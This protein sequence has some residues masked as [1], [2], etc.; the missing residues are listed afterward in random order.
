MNTG[1][2]AGWRAAFAG[3]MLLAG[4]AWA[5]GPDAKILEEWRRDA[6]A[7]EDRLHAKQ[8]QDAWNRSGD[9]VDSMVEHLGE[10]QLARELLASAASRRALAAAGLGREEEAVWLWQTAQTLHPPYRQANLQAYGPPG[11]LL[12]RHRSRL[13]W[14]IPTPEVQLLPEDGGGDLRPPRK[15]SGE[16]PRVPKAVQ[17]GGG[18]LLRIELVVDA[19]GGVSRPV[20]LG[21]ARHPAYAYRALES[22]RTWRFQPA[23]SGQGRVPVLFRVYL[24]SRPPFEGVAD[25]QLAKAE[26]LLRRGEWTA[27]AAESRRQVES[28]LAASDV[29]DRGPFVRALT[30]L[31]V[32]EAS[33]GRREEALWHWREA[34][35]LADLSQ[36]DLSVYG[37]AGRFLLS[38]PL[39]RR[40]EPPRQMAVSHLVGGAVQ[41][42]R[43]PA[44][45]P[46]LRLPSWLRAQVVVDAEGRLHEPVLEGA[47]DFKTVH[48]I[49]A[50][51]RTL[52]L[53]PARQPQGEPL[54]VF[55]DLPAAAPAGLPLAR[56]AEL[57]KSGD[58][59]REALRGREWSK[60]RQK[61]DQLLAASL[62][63][64]EVSRRQAALALTY[65]ALAAAGEGNRAAAGCRWR[66]AQ[67]LWPALYDLDLSEFGEA[68]TSLRQW[69]SAAGLSEAG[70]PRPRG[71]EE[72]SVAS[73]Y[74]PW[75][76]AAKFPGRARIKAVTDAAGHVRES[77]IENL[78]PAVLDIAAR[79]GL[80]SASFQP[81]AGGGPAAL[82]LQLRVVFNPASS[83]GAPRVDGVGT[84]GH[85][86]RHPGKDSD[87]APVPRLPPL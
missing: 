1:S 86:F 20:L 29:A 79:D 81:G 49:F 25:G 68:G 69:E 33:L 82:S 27:A 5:E 18:E 84:W 11:E 62:A 13:A 22:L 63:Q 26:D 59:I 65:R 12:T 45:S 38:R 2:I 85:T 58:E 61:A 23:E 32:A 56:L 87:G 57:P 70:S 28:L 60:A 73:L 37:E 40:D 19:E 51:V 71:G 24:A 9:L 72:P 75:V 48:E 46:P 64:E 44:G 67:D 52:R 21:P 76:R 41:A 83:G 16:E 78:V 4:P 39:R 55:W 80:C 36:E 53:E 77:R 17:A 47:G 7:V 35:S 34:Q 54:T 74:T 6:Q 31:A 3:L 15:L 30:Q 42:P 14:Q 10:G 50:A 8:W 43:L 66:L